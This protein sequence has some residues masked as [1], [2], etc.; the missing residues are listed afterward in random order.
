MKLFLNIK[1][2]TIVVLLLSLFLAC[3]NTEQKTA[4]VEKTITKHN[5]TQKVQVELPQQRSFTAE[6]LISGTA[7]PNQM[8]KLFAME[9]G[10][11]TAILKDVGDKVRKGQVIAELINPK[12]EQIVADAEANIQEVSEVTP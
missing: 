12:V 3:S 1:I 9:S 5:K 8:V 4:A 10:Y 11:V 7:Q 6:V 2:I